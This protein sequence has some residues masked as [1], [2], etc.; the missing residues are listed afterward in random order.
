MTNGLY[1]SDPFPKSG[2]FY[3][4]QCLVGKGCQS[5]GCCYEI[6]CS[7]FSPDPIR[8]TQPPNEPIAGARRSRYVGQSG[9]TLHKRQRGHKEKKTNVM[10]RHS[11][12]YHTEGPQPT[13]TMKKLRTSRTV[14]DRLVWESQYI[15][16]YDEMDPG[17]LM[18]G[19]GE[20]GSNKMVRFTCEASR[21]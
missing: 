10:A 11:Q 9:T 1:K 6:S 2:C 15:Q 4:E 21:I 18:N 12:E 8:L 19:K 17:V 16:S 14:L 13:Y 3:G 7:W 20:W 5:V